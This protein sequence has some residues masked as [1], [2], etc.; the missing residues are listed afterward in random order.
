MR[1]G[2]FFLY[3]A[4]A[5]AA[6]LI[7][8]LPLRAEHAEEATGDA[9]PAEVHAVRH[10]RLLT[11]GA[12]IGFLPLIVMASFALW[13]ILPIQFMPISIWAAIGREFWLPFTVLFFACAS[14]LVPIRSRRALVLLVCCLVVFVGVFTSWRLHRPKAYDY[15][16]NMLD[17]VCLQTSD[18]TCGAAALVTL[19]DRIGI[20]ATEGEMAELSG[21]IPG[22]GVSDFQAAAG[23][24]EKL[25]ML[26][27]SERVAIESCKAADLPSLPTPFLAGVKYSFWFDHMICVLEV[28][29]DQVV[30]GDPL[31]GRV[32]WSRRQFE[33][34]WR[35]VV[36]VL[37]R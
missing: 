25:R 28:T 12:L 30:V 27:R 34:E 29:E 37:R 26:N 19:L 10:R 17:G 7:A 14:Q 4:L 24:R 15:R 9:S 13:P 36:T 21:T 1:P 31:E 2:L 23:L 32:V 16:R 3:T 6:A 8:F 22:R 18:Y 33:S 35:G 5:I 11:I 20:E